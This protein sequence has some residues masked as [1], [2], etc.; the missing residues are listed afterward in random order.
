MNTAQTFESITQLDWARYDAHFP[1]DGD[2]II[3]VLKGHLL[4]ENLFREILT[5]QLAFPDVLKGNSGASF[6]C[7]QII[8]LVQA[9]TPH[10]DEEPWL[11]PAAKRLNNLRNDIAHELEP[12]SV[13]TRVQELVQFTMRT[14]AAKQAVERV[15]VPD[16]REFEVVIIG[17][18]SCLSALKAVLV[19]NPEGL[20]A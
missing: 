15:G 7:H 19:L 13:E 5:L 17:M 12:R 20:R 2:L 1:V 14:P 8:C 10:S 16:G 6:Q 3:Q 11:W 9:L 4:V 18:C